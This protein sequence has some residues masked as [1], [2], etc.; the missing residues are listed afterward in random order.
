M[1]SLSP[2]LAQYHKIHLCYLGLAHGRPSSIFKKVTLGVVWCISQQTQ[3]SL[4]FLSHLQEK[5]SW[6]TSKQPGD[7]YM[8]RVLF[9]GTQ[10]FLSPPPPPLERERT[11]SSL[12]GGNG[13]VYLLASSALWKP[14]K[15]ASMLTQSS[16]ACGT[17]GRCSTEA[18]P[19]K[20]CKCWHCASAPAS[21]FW[22]W[23]TACLRD[24]GRISAPSD[25]SHFWPFPFLHFFLW[26]PTDPLY[27]F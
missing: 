21:G 7:E 9:G 16:Q 27:A 15:L 10:S 19:H 18:T 20:P 23:L 3:A 14:T 22:G 17:L 26:Q 8:N 25:P 4:F 12:I 5:L 1:A 24:R 6:V 2:P 13:H 11:C